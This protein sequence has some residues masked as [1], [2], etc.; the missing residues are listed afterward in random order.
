MKILTVFPVLFGYL[1]CIRDVLGD[2]PICDSV[3]NQAK[4]LEVVDFGMSD[5]KTRDLFIQ[6]MFDNS[7]KIHLFII[8]IML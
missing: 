2:Y 3:T 4:L 8:R 5:K 1:C 6:I 7:G